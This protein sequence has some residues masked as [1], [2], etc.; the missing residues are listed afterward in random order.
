MHATAN[1]N[2]GDKAIQFDLRGNA[3]QSYL[4][5]P[6]GWFGNNQF[7]LVNKNSN[8]CLSVPGGVGKS[9]C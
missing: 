2:N 8:L 7:K 1:K 6:H 4:I 9:R 3:M 5:K